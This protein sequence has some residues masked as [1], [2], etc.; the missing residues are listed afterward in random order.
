MV[1]TK[2][3]TFYHLVRWFIVALGGRG[4][5]ALKYYLATNWKRVVKFNPRSSYLR[6]GTRYP[7][8]RRLFRPHSR[9][10]HFGEGKT[11]LLLPT[12]DLISFQP[13]T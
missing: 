4:V 6:K 10:W 5:A 1:I 8:Y 11:L 12:Q 7:L 13:V 9:S 2:C 3:S